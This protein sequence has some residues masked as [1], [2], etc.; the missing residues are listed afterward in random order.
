VSALFAATRLEDIE[1]I[2]A[3][4]AESRFGLHN[5]KLHASGMDAADAPTHSTVRAGHGADGGDRRQFDLPGS[6]ARTVL[7]AEWPVAGDGPDPTAP[8]WH[9]FIGLV[10]ARMATAQEL[11]EQRRVARQLEK[12]ARL[13]SALY[14][15]ANLASAGLDMAD[16]L[17]RIH[18]I[19]G[20]LMFAR[21]F[22]IALYDSEQDSLRFIYFA[23]E[24]DDL[25]LDPE[26]AF[27]ASEIGDSLTLAV[28][29]SGCPAL[30]P[31]LELRRAFGMSEH[32]AGYGPDSA[33]WLGVPMIADGVVR[34]AIVL[35]SYDRPNRYS[36]EDRALLE[37]VAQ[38]ILIAL[39]RRQAHDEL[40]RRVEERTRDLTDEVRERQRGERLQAALYAIADLASSDL[41]MD[42][43]LR[44]IHAVVGELMYARNFYIALYNAE[45]DTRRFIYFADVHDPRT[46][47]L[48][49]EVPAG[50]LSNSLTM[51]VIRHGRPA[52]GASLQLLAEFGLDADPSFGPESLDWL[53]VPMIADGEVRGAV[54]V[55]SYDQ[56]NRFTEEDRALL[57]F[58]AQHILTALERKKLQAE[59][60]LRVEERTCELR[61][62]MRVREQ[63]EERLMHDALHDA[64]TGLPNRTCFYGALE[65]ALARLQRDPGHRF[66]VLF[67]DLDRFKVINDSVGHLFGDLM[68]KEA[69]A[70]LASCVRSEDVVARLGGDEFA[71]LMENIA[72]PED[73][74][75][76]AQ[77]AIQCLSEPM[78]IGGKELFTSASIGITLGEQRY[79][80]A[81]EL[82][83]DADVAMYR[84]KA[85]GRRRFEIFD[86][87]LHQEAL[88]LLDLENDL[89]HAI[90]RD[91]FEPHFQPIVALRDGRVLGYESL[92]RWKH[93]QRGLVLPE[94]FL[95]VA[96]DNGSIEQ[97]DW[98]MLVNTCRDIAA[99]Q[100]D[101]RYVTLNV[102]PR[103]FRSPHLARRLLDE[104]AAHDI[105][106]GCVRIE[107]TED[108]LLDN[109]DQVFTT[110][111]T[112]R[113]AGV[114]AALDDFGTGYS[115]LSYLHRFPLHSLKIDR[116]FV[117]ELR[118]AHDEGGSAAV[119]RAVLALA[120]TLGLEVIA[121][122]IETEA[123]RDMLLELGC[124][125]GQ[126][127]LFSHARPVAEWQA[128]EG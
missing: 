61:E 23:D 51:A 88:Q 94:E 73:A 62:Q 116:S 80:K 111:D 81:E 71:V 127:F 27:P 17:H 49:A 112:L 103:R 44:R 43:T 98:Q 47:D 63:A 24:R 110:L 74:C 11:H 90:Q 82:L 83:R 30:G 18:E 64:L 32:A 60:E 93:P 86:E 12:H 56:A 28:I 128:A 48:E 8:D 100:A 38:H 33:D 77:R 40:E 75:H 66:A 7:S 69:S 106:P 124:E 25:V 118:P 65:H 123:Q 125:C 107:V 19:V 119:V 53:G 37:F 35:Q 41:A 87:R 67:L 39:T 115:S 10:A 79:H 105:P 97:I 117:R 114:L 6:S 36:E 14:A 121:E 46:V 59:L 122:G 72:A 113:R 2:V 104:L 99:L 1:A 109:P 84:A 9:D 55:Q 96:E 31:S 34:G 120:S 89:R 76:T 42:E 54:V 91:E 13:Q 50:Q 57:G 126:G 85:H 20:E 102:S 21:N 68:L 108:A 58:V 70:R 16:M 45:R 4:E 26:R 101:G 78:Q 92:L 22:L 15:V 29:R 3:R 5:L 95:K 52:M